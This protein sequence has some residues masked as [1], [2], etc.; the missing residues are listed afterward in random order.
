MND[1]ITRQL[2][3]DDVAALKQISE[4]TFQDTFGAQNTPANMQAYL[5]DA[6]NLPALTAELKETDSRFYFVE[7][8][9]EPLGYLKLNVNGAQSEAMGSDSL[10]V[11]RIYV[12]PAYKHQGLGT[13][14][15]EQAIALARAEG[16][17]Q[18]WL[19]V[20]EHNEPAK[21][22]Y[23]KFGFQQFS[24]HK[25]VMGDDPQTDLLMKK[26]LD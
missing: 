7:R 23:A 25:F 12:R 11:E 5:Q 9:H 1:L 8:D 21:H 26:Q 18:I 22:F 20:W 24:Q 4:E 10:E 17:H 16:K 14:F 15:I 2:T 19:G 13:A 3:V 6:Y